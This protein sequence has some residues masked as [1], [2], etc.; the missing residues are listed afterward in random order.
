MGTCSG[1]Q[2]GSH[3]EEGFNLI[4]LCL[5]GNIIAP[6]PIAKLFMD[7]QKVLVVVALSV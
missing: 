5:S 2:Q 4:R 6:V 7:A 3:T 1:G